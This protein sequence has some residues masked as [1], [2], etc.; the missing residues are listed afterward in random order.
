MISDK[1]SVRSLFTKRSIYV[2]SWPV[3]PLVKRPGGL[4][5]W[6]LGLRGPVKEHRN[7]WR[8]LCSRVGSSPTQTM[9]PS[10]PPPPSRGRGGGGMVRTDPQSFPLW[11]LPYIS[12]EGI[13]RCKFTILVDIVQW[14]LLAGACWPRLMTYRAH[15]VSPDSLSPQQ[16]THPSLPTFCQRCCYKTVDFATAASQNG[17]CKT[18]GKCHKMI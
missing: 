14:P 1:K 11:N 9:P 16:H 17:V 8:S 12:Q 15:R 4:H 3:K 5:M 7:V 10:P 6:G 13:C 2:R 18:Q